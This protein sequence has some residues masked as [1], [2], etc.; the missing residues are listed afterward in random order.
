MICCKSQLLLITVN[1]YNIIFFGGKLPGKLIPYF[2]VTDNNNLHFF[3][4]DIVPFFLPA[5]HLPCSK[6]SNYSTFILKVQQNWQF[7]NLKR[8]YARSDTLPFLSLSHHPLKRS[9]LF[10]C[11][12]CCNLLLLDIGRSLLISCKSICISSSSTCHGTK[13]RTI[14][15]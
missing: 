8:K 6:Q 1:Q 3:S 11:C 2:S 10:F 14:T 5:A 4:L 12:P 9:V 13:C 7:L 15:K